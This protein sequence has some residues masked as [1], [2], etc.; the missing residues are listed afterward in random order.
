MKIMKRN[1][2]QFIVFAAFTFFLSS[3]LKDNIG[4][5]WTSSLKGKMYATFTKAGVQSFTISPSPDP[6]FYNFQ[7]NIASDAVP[8]KDYTFTLAIDTV[9]LAAY[10]A[11]QYALDTNFI[12]FKPYP[13]AFL[14]MPTSVTIKAG[15]RISWVTIELDSAIAVD[16]STHWIVPIVIKAVSSPD[17]I[18]AANRSSFFLT[19]PIKNKWE[20]T[21]TMKGWILRGGDPV[22]TGYYKGRIYKLKTSGSNS[23]TFNSIISWADIVSDGVGGVGPWTLT[24]DEST[25]PNPV[26]V[27]DATNPAVTTNPAYPN[28]YDPATSTFY[29]KAYWGAGI[30]ARETCDTLVYTGP[31]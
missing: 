28:R 23:V 1:I 17:L 29:I 3:C 14:K 31:Y 18:I 10:N 27:S 5:N 13:A 20:G 19:L 15:S 11:A 16:L 26:T 24:I 25:I 22:R 9:A 12:Y 7:L 21:Y 6:F 8:T 30:G 2:I 4:E